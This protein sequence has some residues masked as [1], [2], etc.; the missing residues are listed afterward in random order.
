MKFNLTKSK[1]I[2]IAVAA[3][4]TVAAAV[5]VITVGIIRNQP[6]NVAI[7]A[8][9]DTFGSFQEREEIAPL[10]SIVKGGSIEANSGKIEHEWW[11]TS[12]FQD[13]LE[14]KYTFFDGSASGKL[15]FS[16]NAL[17]L[18]SLKVKKGDV[19]IDSSV[20]LSDKL[21]YVK[22]NTDEDRAFG[23]NL[24]KKI[25]NQI[26]D[27]I[28]AYDSH[29][30]Y[31]LSKLFTKKDYENLIDEL[32]RLFKS[33]SKNAEFTKDLGE[34]VRSLAKDTVDIIMAN[35]EVSDEVDTVTLGYEQAEARIITITARPLQ[36]SKIIEE[37]YVEIL[38]SEKL[39]VFVKKYNDT[40]TQY[41][42]LDAE[43][44][45]KDARDLYYEL[46]D[47]TDSTI[48]ALCESIEDSAKKLTVQ[49]V[50][51]KRRDTLL[52]FSASYGSDLLFAV[53]F[54]KKG[55]E[56]TD[57]I[58]LLDGDENEIFVYRVESRKDS[59]SASIE[60]SE[61]E[62]FVF[63]YDKERGKYEIAINDNTKYHL[64][65]IKITGGLEIKKGVYSLSL[66]KY[67]EENKDIAPYPTGSVDTYFFDL[68]AT[69][70][71]K[72]RFPPTP[73][74]YTALS[75]IRATDFK[76]W[77]RQFGTQLG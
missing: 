28:F 4:L 35:T 56:K 69:L 22:D 44:A 14:G 48:D 10:L 55:L 46:I 76:K 13:G 71:T 61:E 29:S 7:R 42:G 62:V 72:D 34:L 37:L 8:I 6:E 31:S 2:A 77:L 30:D 59:Y 41:L 66:E 45:D 67:V 18:D 64:H 17:M 49:I 60:I 21:I 26:E 1:A 51:P 20:Y 40:L 38:A 11:K 74:S 25:S 36:L 57:Y 9:A 24:T 68:S 39:K 58:A 19:S 3:V 43:S 27:S 54:G 23:L 73:K 47:A 50:T 70:K 5:T 33:G 15:Y 52:K 16:E 53:D 12:R 75:D 32:D 65:S 63:E